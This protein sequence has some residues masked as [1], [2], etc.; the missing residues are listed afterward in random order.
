MEYR[1]NMEIFTCDPLICTM[2]HPRL[3]VSNQMEDV[4]SLQ[5]VKNLT[6]LT[7]RVGD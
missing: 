2:N 6:R 3:I 7:G 4:I 5:R 1:V